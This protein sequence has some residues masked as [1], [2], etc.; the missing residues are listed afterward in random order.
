MFAVTLCIGQSGC[1]VF[2]SYYPVKATVRDAETDALIPGAQVGVHYLYMMVLNAPKSDSAVTDQLGKA[3]LR[4]ATFMKE[5]TVV[6]KGYL[7]E[8]KL[9]SDPPNWQKSE[10]VNFSI[11]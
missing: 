11:E 10:L 5:W 8:S 2:Y 6:A 1:I 3:D 7:E 9:A 4:A